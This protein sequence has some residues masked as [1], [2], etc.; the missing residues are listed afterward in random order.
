MPIATDLVTLTHELALDKLD[1]IK[2]IV[3]DHE[4]YGLSRHHEMVLDLCDVLG[5]VLASKA[6]PAP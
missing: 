4:A 5:M 3:C 1:R 6:E 2:A